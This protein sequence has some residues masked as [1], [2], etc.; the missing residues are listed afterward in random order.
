MTSLTYQI[1]RK[2]R[3]LQTV[4]NTLQAPMPQP[5][6]KHV[7]GCS[8]YVVASTIKFQDQGPIKVL[9]N[10]HKCRA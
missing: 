2:S 1:F 8:L 10:M 9:D 3:D 5:F 7:Q 4:Y 6:L